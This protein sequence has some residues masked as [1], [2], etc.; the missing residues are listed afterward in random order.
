M[1]QHC[2]G[3]VRLYMNNRVLHRTDDFTV[4]VPSR[5]AYVVDLDRASTRGNLPIRQL[6]QGTLITLMMKMQIFLI[7]NH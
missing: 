2:I 6:A 4:P 1:C 3:Y 7:R 5:N